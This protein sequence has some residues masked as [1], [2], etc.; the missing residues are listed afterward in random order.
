ML[1]ELIVSNRADRLV[2]ENCERE[3]LDE[4]SSDFK[5]GPMTYNMTKNISAYEHGKL[6]DD[7]VN[8]LFQ[9]LDQRL[10]TDSLTPLR[11]RCRMQRHFMLHHCEATEVLP[12]RVFH[13]A[14][15]QGLVRFVEGVLQV[16]QAHQQT[17]RLGRSPNIRAVAVRQS[18]IETIPIDPV[19]QHE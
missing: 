16:M 9:H 12:V 19:C 3:M 17:N 14:F 13:P 10:G 5:G 4:M 8:E 18:H 1:G 7:A 15:Q 6:D 2:G 11:Q